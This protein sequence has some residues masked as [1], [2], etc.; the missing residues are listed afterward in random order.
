[1]ASL[2]LP[3]ASF[4]TTGPNFDAVT[5]LQLGCDSPDLIVPPSRAS[6]CCGGNQATP[7]AFYAYDADYL[8]FRYRMDDD[9]GHGGGFDQYVWTALMQVPSGNRFQYQYQLSLN[10]KN[11]S[12]DSIEIWGNTVASDTPFPPFQAHPY[13]NLQR[14]P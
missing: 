7:P 3:A 9:P 14:V 1:M 12:G 4:A 6:A 10:G 8:Y 2:F 11:A 5:C 13:E